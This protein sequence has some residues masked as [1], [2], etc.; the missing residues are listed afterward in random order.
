MQ[1]KLSLTLLF[2]TIFAIIVFIISSG[3]GGGSGIT[4]PSSLLTSPASGKIAYIT[5][6]VKWPKANVSGSYIISSKDNKGELTASMTKDT[7]RI[8]VRIYEDK[9][10]SEG[11]PIGTEPIGIGTIREPDTTAT[12][13]VH[14]KN[15][16]D[17]PNSSDVLPVVPVKIW[18]GA[19]PD[20][21]GNSLVNPISETLKDYTVVVGNNAINLQLGD[22]E[23]KVW[24]SPQNITLPYYFN[25][26]N[27]ISGKIAGSTPT[28]VITPGKIGNI[29]IA[30]SDDDY[31]YPP[32]DYPYPPDDTPT[33]SETPGTDIIAQLMITY[34]ADANGVIPE[35]KPVAN[36][37]VKFWLNDEQK[38]QASLIPAEGTTD[39]DGY[40]EIRFETYTEGTYTINAGFQPD[41]DNAPDMVYPAVCTVNVNRNNSEETPVPTETPTPIPTVTQYFLN[42]QA[43][44]GTFDM[45]PEFTSDY[46]DIP[47]NTST[48]TATLT[49]ILPND[50]TQTRI[51]IDGAE[52]NFSSNAGNISST[53]VTQNGTCQVGFSCSYCTYSGITITAH[54][55]PAPGEP[56][57]YITS[58]CNIN[59]NSHWMLHQNFEYGYRGLKLWDTNYIF[60]LTPINIFVSSKN[61]PALCDAFID[62]PGA[63]STSGCAYLYFNPNPNASGESRM[64][65]ST[66]N[67]YSN[68][69]AYPSA[70]GRCYVKCGDEALP[71][72][73]WDPNTRWRGYIDFNYS[74]LAF[75]ADG[76]I[77]GPD[78]NVMTSYRPDE[79][80][81]VKMQCIS[82]YDVNPNQHY[83]L[84]TYYYINGIPY[85][86]YGPFVTLPPY[87][88]YSTF[89]TYGGSMCYDEIEVYNLSSYTKKSG[90]SQDISRYSKKPVILKENDIYFHK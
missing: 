64:A 68:L 54:A 60:Q 50:P 71:P 79:W 12:I 80:L 29:M 43:N 72:Y 14:I 25:K 56:D 18:V 63:R 73:S 81:S 9:P 28:P 30:H 82:E 58:V 8:E 3:C 76:T 11:D 44:P 31:P 77:I 55:R 48:I 85:G 59:L 70:E 34:P 74:I 2:I 36:K 32:D 35:P 87:I 88:C 16:P 66:Y 17:D 23:L 39:P 1:D 89:N 37:T 45:I 51:P 42:L 86:P 47:V 24:A 6:N 33:P 62:F 57:V 90:A 19:F 53:G 7:R 41:P 5:I 52:V 83:N 13:A 40:C 67:S 22:Y 38:D 61:D 46:F 27:N 84:Y 20:R 26:S 21:D 49:K 65:W 15:N 4:Q 78:Q 10:T 75:K 69:S